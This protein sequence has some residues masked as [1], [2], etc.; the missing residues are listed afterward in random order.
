[1]RLLLLGEDW[2]FEVIVTTETVFCLSHVS[3]LGRGG[4][5]GDGGREGVR[6]GEGIHV[7]VGEMEGVRVDVG[8]KEIR[9]GVTGR[10][11]DLKMVVRVPKLIR[12]Y[13]STGQTLLPLLQMSDT[14][15][16]LQNYE[17]NG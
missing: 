8:G 17:R 4:G 16:S 9:E 1:M 3:G 14:L 13:L 10:R 11:E 6:E 7:D 5:R 12:S 15:L 2:S